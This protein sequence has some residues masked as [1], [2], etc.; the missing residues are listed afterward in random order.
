MTVGVLTGTTVMLVM[1]SS[2][3]QNNAALDLVCDRHWN[4]PLVVSL[5][6]TS[7]EAAALTYVLIM[8]LGTIESILTHFQLRLQFRVLKIKL[9]YAL[10]SWLWML[11][12]FIYEGVEAQQICKA[13]V[14]T[15]LV[16]KPTVWKHSFFKVSSLFI[17][18]WLSLW[19]N[20][21]CGALDKLRDRTDTVLC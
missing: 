5:V 3:L 17:L 2:Y 7:L 11:C 10:C 12:F 8:Y 15:V 14:A 13:T 18:F 1:I 19:A 21:S 9:D 4:S 6:A 16:L 20:D